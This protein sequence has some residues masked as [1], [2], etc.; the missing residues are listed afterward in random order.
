MKPT[1]CVLSCEHAVNTIP[2]PYQ[3][4]FSQHEAVLQTHR[5]IDIGALEI[6]RH[7]HKTLACKFEQATVSRLLI[8]CNRSLNHKQC[9]FFFFKT[10]S[11][12][13]KQTLIDTYYRP[14][15]ENL[16]PIIKN[17]I[18]QGA[19]VLHLSIHSFTPELNG[20]IRNAAI[21]LLYDYTRHGEREVAR[22]WRGLIELQTPAFRVRMN[23]PY[24]GKSDGFTSHL[25]KVHNEHDYLGLEIE[26]NQALLSE[27]ESRKEVATVL[28]TSLQELMQVL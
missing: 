18:D 21:G 8:D 6:A 12:K 23:Y 10:L 1:V 24:H 28:A 20:K 7:L 27:D 17:H 3:P 22:V 11:A 2:A 26:C 4:L 15:L 5:G 9:F 25:R 19:Q 16:Q 14:Y 13:D